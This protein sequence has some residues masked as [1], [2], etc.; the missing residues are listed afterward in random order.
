MKRLIENILAKPHIEN[1]WLSRMNALCEKQF[2]NENFARYMNEVEYDPYREALTINTTIMPITSKIIIIIFI[3][4]YLIITI[5][6][7][8]T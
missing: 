8:I 7:I 1:E 6:T 2:Q 5:I 4:T 3:I